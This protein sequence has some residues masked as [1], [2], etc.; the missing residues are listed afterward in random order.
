MFLLGASFFLAHVED[1]HTT[2]TDS[3]SIAACG[4][5]YA[6]CDYFTEKRTLM[7]LNH[8]VMSA[9]M[10]NAPPNLED[11]VFVVGFRFEH[12]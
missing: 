5:G 9:Q 10:R 12:I 2:K 3:C 4:V 7:C 1:L 11:R 6:R 8:N